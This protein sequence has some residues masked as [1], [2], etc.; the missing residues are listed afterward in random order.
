MLAERMILVILA[1]N[2][3]KIAFVVFIFVG[4]FI[5][6]VAIPSIRLCLVDDRLRDRDYNISR[7]KNSVQD[8]RAPGPRSRNKISYPI[9]IMKGV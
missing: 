8:V 5:F 6:N 1:P 2:F 4:E 7:C 3:G 9:F